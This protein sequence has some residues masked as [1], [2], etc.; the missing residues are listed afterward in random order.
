MHTLEPGFF[1]TNIPDPEINEQLLRE[2][3]KQ[4]DP[5]IQEQFGGNEYLEECKSVRVEINSNS[6]SDKPVEVALFH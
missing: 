2:C 1:K 3:W 4:V 5:S 6:R